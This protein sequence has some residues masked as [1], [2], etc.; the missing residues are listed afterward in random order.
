MKRTLIFL[1][2][3]LSVSSAAYAGWWNTLENAAHSVSSTVRSVKNTGNELAP[4]SGTAQKP[5]NNTAGAPTAASTGPAAGNAKNIVSGNGGNA[6]A[7]GGDIYSAGAIYDAYDFIPG[8][9]VLFYDDFSNTDVGEFPRKWTLKGPGGG[10]NS[11]EVV[12]YQGKRW[13]RSQPPQAKDESMGDTT[14]YIRYTGGFPEKFTVEFDAVLDKTGGGWNTRYGLLLNRPN[15]YPGGG[16]GEIDITGKHAHS[17]NTTTQLDMSDGNVHHIAISVNGTFVKAYVDNR[18]VINDP[19]ALAGPVQYIG[20]TMG[21]HNWYSNDLMFTNF[22]VAEGGKDIQSALDA[23]GKVVTHGIYFDTGS[24]TIKPQSL[25][26]LKKILS[27]LQDRPG[28]KFSIEG[29]TDN[30]GAQGLNQTL[31]ENRAKAVKAWLVSKGI[32]ADRLRTKGWGDTK[33]IA[34]NDTA[35]GRANNRRV[36]F[37]K[38]K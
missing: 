26:T 1:V 29:H 34:S 6:S 4:G 38:L 8:N 28:L 22:R 11:V 23:T 2:A 17:K 36:E 24:A 7:G 31:S 19:D 18:R 20:M 10:G 33:P 37:V 35:V 9:K 30:R 3:F 13:L 25:P 32:S 16:Y 12:K 21:S 5:A 15:E 27:L 14:L